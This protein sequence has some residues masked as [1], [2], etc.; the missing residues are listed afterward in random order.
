MSDSL[1]FSSL[2]ALIMPEVPNCPIPL[3]NQSIFICLQKFCRE[4]HAWNEEL[5]PL[6]IRA[7]VA[8]YPIDIPYDYARL[9]SIM[10]VKRNERE[11]RPCV[12]YKMQDNDLSLITTPAQSEARSLVIRA[13]FDPAIGTELIS[14][15]LYNDWA[16][17]IADAVKSRLMLMPEKTWSNPTLGAV[18]RSD[19]INGMANAKIKVMNENSLNRKNRV[20]PRHKFA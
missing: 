14:E 9:W 7:D 3:I 19:A 1:P 10:T 15:S 11:L 12:D 13:A 2:H 8:V 5:E 4:T 20:S 18:Y 16:I 17:E 6:S